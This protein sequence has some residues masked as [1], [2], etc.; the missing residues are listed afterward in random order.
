[1]SKKKPTAP[2]ITIALPAGRLAPAQFAA[3]NKVVQQYQLS[4][5]L[6]TMQNLRLLDVPEDKAA[7]IKEELNEAG[8]AIKGPG[9]FPIPRVCAGRPYCNLAQADPLRLSDAI[10]K[11]LGNRT[12]V[13]PKFKIAI[14]ACP[15]NCSGAVLAD[16]GVVAGRSSYDIYAGGKGGPQPR[17]GKR[18]LRKVA[19]DEAVEVIEQLVAFHDRKT[20]KKKRFYKLLA[21]P[22]FPFAVE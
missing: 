20:K 15:A 5:Y 2:Y 3:V 21:D 19:A 13:K 14:A 22:D 9:Q 11:R 10:L 12:N 16:I 8:V 6:T 7:E 17:A 18:I 4:T 1:M